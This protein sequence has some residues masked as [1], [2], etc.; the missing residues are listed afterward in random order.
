MQCTGTRGKGRKEISRRLT[1][2]LPDTERGPGERESTVKRQILPSQNVPL[3]K[4]RYIIIM[5]VCVCSFLSQQK[6]SIKLGMNVRLLD[7][8]NHICT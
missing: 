3:M 8:T 7:V 5:S 4:S 1:V 2:S 6:L